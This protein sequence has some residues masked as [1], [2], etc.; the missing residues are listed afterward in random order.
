[1][2]Q[3]EDSAEKQKQ[4]KEVYGIRLPAIGPKAA[5][6]NPAAKS[7]STKNLM[8]VQQSAHPEFKSLFSPVRAKR[9]SQLN[10][11]K[12]YQKYSSLAKN[13]KEYQL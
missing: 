3:Q 1:M 9:S 6:V 13:D 11:E 2:T 5:A 12:S 7:S 4:I 8:S 10:D